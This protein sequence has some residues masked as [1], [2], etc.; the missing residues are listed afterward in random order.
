MARLVEATAPRRWLACASSSPNMPRLVDEPCCF[1][2]FERELASLPGEYRLFLAKPAAGCVAVRFL[3]PETAEMKRLYVR[4]EHRG[5]GLGRALADAAIAAAREA[6]C[7]PHRARHAAEDARSAGA[8]S[9]ARLP[10]DCALLG[11]TPPPERSASSSGFPD[12]LHELGGR[13]LVLERDRDHLPPRA[14][15][16][17]APAMRST[18]QSPPFASTCG[19][20]AAI[21]ASGVSS[22]NQVTASTHSSAATTASRSARRVERPLGPL[23]EPP[24]RAVGVQRDEERGAERARAGEI[25]DVA[26][27]QDVEHAVGED[28]RARERADP[29]LERGGVPDLRLERR[30]LHARGGLGFSAGG[31]AGRQRSSPG[32]AV[33]E[34]PH[35]LA[36]AAGGARDLGGFRPRL[37]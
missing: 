2:D 6:G 23:A 3:D 13:A 24:R 32:I 10:P 17:P 21:S 18:G 4:A 33:L 20:A 28:E 5:R 27:V 1:A 22:S 7:T 15:T 8:L 12:P 35:H 29:V 11:Q 37:R 31:G 26:A 34:H 30:R 16:P 36:H 9:S 19:L 25:G 14:S